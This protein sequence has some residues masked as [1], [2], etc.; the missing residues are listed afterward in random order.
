MGVGKLN[1]LQN[2]RHS[3]TMVMGA[4]DREGTANSVGQHG[5]W[6]HDNKC[7]PNPLQNG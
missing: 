7:I 6:D 4:L 1:L 2:M 5:E 3:D